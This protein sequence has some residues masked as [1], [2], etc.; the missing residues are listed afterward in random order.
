MS[1]VRVSISVEEAYISRILEISQRLQSFGMD[2]EQTLPSIGVISGLIDSDQIDC[3]K[4]E[5]VQQIEPEQNYQ[6]AP[7]ESDIQ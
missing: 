2:V 1:K 3:L 4:I 5:G 7:P 6:I